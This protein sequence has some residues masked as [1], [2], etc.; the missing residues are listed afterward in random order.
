MSRITADEGHVGILEIPEIPPLSL[1]LEKIENIP[2]PE[3]RRRSDA[4]AV[5]MYGF[6][7]DSD[8]ACMDQDTVVS[9]QSLKRRENEWI[10]VLS[11]WDRYKSKTKKLCRLGIPDSV[12]PRVWMLL[13]GAES[14][15]IPGKFSELVADN[16]YQKIFDVIE[17]DLHRTYPCHQMFSERDGPGYSRNN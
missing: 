10:Q 8:D 2:Y 16:S 11:N 7:L 5:D 1:L 9:V 4:K 13:S 14:R 6:Y 3:H 15:K 17:R 12:R